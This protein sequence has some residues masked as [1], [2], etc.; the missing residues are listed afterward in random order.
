MKE[1]K[2]IALVPYRDIKFRYV[3]DHY[4]VHLNGTCIYNNSLCE[5]ENDYPEPIYN[6]E[7]DDYDDPEMIVRVYR[8]SLNQKI[9][10]LYRQWLFEKC[11]GY[12]WSYKNGK[13]GKYFHYR[14]PKW[15]YAFIFGAYYKSKKFFK[16]YKN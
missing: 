8:L 1:K 3:S 11:V 15:L 6:E 2:Q 7:T 13:R 16:F 5:F 14:N 10:W 4:D 9:K 12:H